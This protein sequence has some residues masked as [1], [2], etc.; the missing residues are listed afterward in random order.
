MGFV[1]AVTRSR[2]YKELP[3][4]RR[5]EHLGL[6]QKKYLPN[7]D[8]F[9]Y[10]VT[11][12]NDVNGNERLTAL[13]RELSAAKEALTKTRSE[14]EIRPGLF[15][16]PEGHSIYRFCLS[17]GGEY[18]IFITDTLPNHYTPRIHVQLRAYGLWERGVN[19]ILEK[20][21]RVL[22]SLFKEFDCT[23]TKC[24]ENR[25]DFCF[26]TNNIQNPNEIFE[27]RYFERHLKTSLMGGVEYWRLEKHNGDLDI[28][29]NYV[30]MGDRKSNNIFAR[31]YDKT[32]EVVEM[33]Y[34]GFFFRIWRER[35]LINAYD[36]YCLRYAYERKSYSAIHKARLMYYMEHGTDEDAKQR[37]RR[38]LNNKN[39]TS[40]HYSRCAKAE[41]L[42]DV[43][44]VMNIEFQTMRKF[45][46]NANIESLPQVYRP[47]I[48]QHLS[49]LFKIVDN[50][51]LF[52][53]YLT[54]KTVCFVKE[55]IKNKEP[56]EK[57][58]CCD[59]WERLRHTKL[60]GIKPDRSFIREYYSEH[61][62]RAE[63]RYMVN[64]PALNADYSDDTEMDFGEDVT[65][66][67]ACVNDNDYKK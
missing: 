53:N 30:G 23:V 54:D 12:D 8:N 62:Q 6:T 36:E 41:G 51:A 48:P 22:E 29:T 35:G 52:I 9:Y 4:D 44:T 31:F 55:K 20:S 1:P 15:V 37:I 63:M 17:S 25:I 57:E 2:L 16:K 28:I 65:D 49:R 38:V 27:K 58:I 64:M 5:E 61:D 45:Y 7:I 60:E 59:W 14:V 19:E 34:K 56:G 26:H 66:F 18:D 32:R 11:L 43:T 33:G 10:N 13:F 47:G 50:R 42:P 39:S 67:L 21:Y 40:Y 24:V 46:Y 3:V